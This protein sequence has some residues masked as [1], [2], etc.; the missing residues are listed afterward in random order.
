MDSDGESTRSESECS[1]GLAHSGARPLLRYLFRP[2][3]PPNVNDRRRADPAEI[4]EIKKRSRA[5]KATGKPREPAD[6]PL[7]LVETSARQTVVRADD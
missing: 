4:I 2:S 7:E 5:N 6:F 3:V 1:D